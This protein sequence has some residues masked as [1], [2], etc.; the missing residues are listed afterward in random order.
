MHAAT[1]S[2]LSPPP[3]SADPGTAGEV[4]GVRVDVEDPEFCPRFTARL[5]EDVTIGPSPAWLKARLMAAGQRPINNVVDITNYAML[6]TGQPLHAFDF[7]LVAGGHLVVRPAREGE[8]MTTLDDAERTLDASMHV[9]C[10]DDGPTSIAGLM[11]GARSEVG[12]TTTRVLMEAANWNGPKLQRTSTKLRLRTEASGRF[13]KGLAPEQ[14]M[15]GLIVATQLMLDL[16]GATLQDGT[17]DVGGPGPAP[18]VIRLRDERTARLLGATVPRE[19]AAQILERLGFGVEGAADGLDVTVPAFRRN[20]VTREA[21]LIEEVARIWGLDKL[22]ATLPSRRGATGRL[23]P[24]QRA[25]R[26]LEDELAGVGLSEA[27]GWSFAAPDLIDRLRLPA[28]DPRRAAPVLRNPMSEDQAVLRTTL[29]GSLLDSARVNRS[30]GIADARLFEAGAVYFDRPRAGEPRGTLPDERNHLGALLTG[31]LRPATWRESEPPRADFFAVKSVLE[32]ALGAIRVPWSV[33]PAREPFLHPGRS[34]RVLIAGEPAGWI[35]ELHPGV[36]AAW[37][38]EQVAAFEVHL[39]A[40]LA[41]APPVPVY[42]DVTIVPVRA[43]GP[44]LV[45]PA[46]GVGRAGARRRPRRRRRA[47]RERLGVR[48]LPE[49][50]PRLAGAAARVPRARPHADRRGG[51]PAPGQDRRRGGRQ[52]GRRA[53]WLASRCSERRATRARSRPRCCTAT[54]SSSCAT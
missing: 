42:R 20:D 15:D 38:L 33:E 52:A 6:L 8:K 34:A 44:R 13:E 31:A 47:A 49:R 22:P 4:A 39:D 11:G 48:R 18:A 46:R 36:A 14:A 21:D 28:G 19:E 45:V 50:G 25:R 27:V 23:E 24:E 53:A 30:R 3:W 17:I 12:P 2:E 16:T 5:F 29:L 10:D 9:I 51:R 54:R 37:D 40:V 32:A 35:G 7:D 26:R 41:A 1:G 43:P